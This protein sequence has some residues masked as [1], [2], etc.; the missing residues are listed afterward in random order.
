MTLLKILRSQQIRIFFLNRCNFINK[1][2]RTG[3]ETLLFHGKAGE[4][5]LHFSMYN[6]LLF[7]PWKAWCGLY[8]ECGLYIVEVQN[9]KDIFYMSKSVYTAMLVLHDRPP[10]GRQWA[11]H[12]NTLKIGR[13]ASTLTV[14]LPP[15]A[16]Q[17]M[18]YCRSVTY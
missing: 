11:I 1:E 5:L 6:L 8:Y 15:R 13:H 14:Y 10:L 12:E 3:T 16:N 18:L 7:T 2:H 17:V 9:C 4:C